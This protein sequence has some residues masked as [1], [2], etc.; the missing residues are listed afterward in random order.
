MLT[1]APAPQLWW[2]LCGLTFLALPLTIW[3]FQK[4]DYDVHYQGASGG[5]ERGMGRSVQVH[6]PLATLHGAARCP[7]SA[8]PGA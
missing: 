1:P 8:L 5:E 3:E 2:F 4:Q 7:P 6:P